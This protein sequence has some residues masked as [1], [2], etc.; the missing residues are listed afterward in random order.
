KRRRQLDI[1]VI[2]S[3][4]FEFSIKHAIPI[5]SLLPFVQPGQRR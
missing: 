2:D 5:N 4:G 1:L 3:A